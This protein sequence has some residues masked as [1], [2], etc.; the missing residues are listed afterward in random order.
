MSGQHRTNGKAEPATQETE[1]ATTTLPKPVIDN[2]TQAH[3]LYRTAIGL[4]AEIELLNP[5]IAE[6]QRLLDD[7]KARHVALGDQQFAL[8]ENAKTFHEMAFDHCKKYGFG[9]MP[10]TFDEMVKVLEENV[11]RLPN[12]T[13]ALE[14]SGGV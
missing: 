6:A 12:G 14:A 4:S 11:H 2:L 8:R 7:L 5:K 1:A 3:D 10:G 13:A 9:P